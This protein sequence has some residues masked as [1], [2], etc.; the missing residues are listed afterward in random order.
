MTLVI[1]LEFSIT[2]EMVKMG[3][4]GARGKLITKKKPETK[5]L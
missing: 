4:S 2:L 3:L 5:I 1:N